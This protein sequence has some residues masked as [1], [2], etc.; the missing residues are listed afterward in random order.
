MAKRSVLLAVILA[1]AASIAAH[2]DSLTYVN[3]RFGTTLTFPLDVFDEIDPPPANGD[4]RRFRSDDGAELA[5]YGQFNT[6]DKNPESL[7]E[8]EAGIVGEDGGKVTY[9]A[10]GKDWAVL[11]GTIGETI[12]YQ[13]HE[14]SSDGSVIYSMDMRYPALRSAFYDRLVGEIADSLKG[15]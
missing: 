5:A 13:R 12:F 7:V 2:A 14:I 9:S 15:P 8:W 3:E 6:L 1:A 10:S 4:G 11:S